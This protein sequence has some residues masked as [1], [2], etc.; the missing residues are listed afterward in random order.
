[1]VKPTAV[2]KAS[3]SASADCWINITLKVLSRWG[4]LIYSCAVSP[5]KQANAE[6]AK[7]WTNFRKIPSGDTDHNVRVM[8]STSRM[9]CLNTRGNIT[10]RQGCG[11][12]TKFMLLF[13]KIVFLEGEETDRI[14]LSAGLSGRGLS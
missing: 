7:N 11:S 6:V 10:Q 8:S 3:A 9:H 12:L 5:R 2:I 4:V 13:V 14:Q 1:M